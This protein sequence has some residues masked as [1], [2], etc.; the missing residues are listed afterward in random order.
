MDNQHNEAIQGTHYDP[1][2]RERIRSHF[3]ACQSAM[4]DGVVNEAL[5]KS[6]LP[7][8]YTAFAKAIAIDVVQQY[9]I[10]VPSVAFVMAGLTTG[11][12]MGR[13]YAKTE[14]LDVVE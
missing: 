13:D 2:T 1:E 14:V 7:D 9:G 3:L 11:F 8:E 5:T 6:G 12:A 4:R 10:A